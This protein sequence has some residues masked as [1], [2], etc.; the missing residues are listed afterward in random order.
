MK[1]RVGSN[2]RNI[3]NGIAKK[4]LF[5]CCLGLTAS[6]AIGLQLYLLRFGIGTHGG[7]IHSSP[8]LSQ[9]SNS[10]TNRS[11]DRETKATT[12]TFA[13][14]TA[15]VAYAISL[16]K[17]S[18]KQ[19]TDAGLVDAALVLRHS[20]HKISIRNHAESQSRY[21]YRMYALVLKQA[22]ACSH[23]LRTAGFEIVL[24]DQQPVTVDEIQGD[25][26][27]NNIETEWCCGSA[28]FIKLY[29]YALPEPLVVHV[30]IDFAFFKPMDDLFD[31]ILYPKDSVKGQL[32]RSKIPLERPDLS[33]SMPDTIDAFITR[34]WAQVIPGRKA[35]YQAGFLVARRNPDVLQQAIAIVKEGNYKEGYDLRNGW[36]GAGYGAFVGG[37]HVSLV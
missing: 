16:I 37:K 29:V 11:R 2:K 17:C 22:E 30:D 20:I 15:T 18:D 3:G 5:L 33:S 23:V 31:A 35:L 4:C 34:D 7:A 14:A 19:T 10:V 12:K 1:P 24:I 27:R 13:N 21:D 28:E 26:L 6:L 36:G 32:A 9:S 8:A 25:H